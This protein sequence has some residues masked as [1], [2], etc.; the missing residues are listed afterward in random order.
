MGEGRG[1]GGSVKRNPITLVMFSCGHRNKPPLA[2]FERDEMWTRAYKLT[3]CSAK[4]LSQV[5]NQAVL[6]GDYM[7]HPH[8]MGWSAYPINGVK[9]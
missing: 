9:K 3:G 4:R 1:E 7:M 6:N 2:T 5:I 8:S